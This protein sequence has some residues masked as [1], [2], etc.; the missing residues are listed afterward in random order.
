MKTIKIA[1]LYYDL[2]NLYGEN[3]NVRALEKYLNKSF[4]VE[5]TNLTINDKIDFNKYD[6][7]YIGS[8]NNESFNLVLNDIMKYQNDIKK[9]IND[10]FFIIT[11]NAINLFGK[12]YKNKNNIIPCL[13]VLKYTSKEKKKRI[14]GEQ[15]L[16]S[17]II[18]EDI[19]G[20]YNRSSKLKNI[21]E[22]MLFETVKG[23]GTFEGIKHSNFYGTYLLGPILIRNPYFTE[24]L[25]KEIC[26][27]YDTEYKKVNNDLE[28]KAY[29]QYK[30]NFLKK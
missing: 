29:E 10:K 26:K 12:Y 9:F 25:A 11:G 14:V 7:Y 13:D 18:K 23:Y 16:K 21:H 6:I 17:R 30:Y 24:Y 1:H 27:K 19:I 8:G 28:V 22:K 20:F 2:M 4:N 3:G 5:I 15:I